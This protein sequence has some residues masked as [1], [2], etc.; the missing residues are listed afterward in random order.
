MSGP[1]AARLG[2]NIRPLALFGFAFM[3]QLGHLIEH[4]IKAI[5][6]AGLLGAAAD[7]EFSHLLFNG[8]IALV[9]LALVVLY[10]RNP[11]VYPLVVL[12][13]FHGIEH[14]YIYA[15]FLVRGITDGPG[16]L[17]AGGAIGVLPIDRLDLHNLY[18]GFEMILMVLGFTHE[19]DGLLE[20]A[21]A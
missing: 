19:S 17:G 12:S 1:T 3:A 14:V 18:N 2:A 6:G 8:L 7:N 16:L 11:W 9:A 4:I 20:Q 10:R 5:T 13:V 21:E 15:Q